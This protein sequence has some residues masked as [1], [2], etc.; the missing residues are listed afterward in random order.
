MISRF[1]SATGII[2]VPFV[3]ARPMSG[4]GF[5]PSTILTH[6]SEQTPEESND[7]QL[8]DDVVVAAVVVVV[9]GDVGVAAVVVSSGVGFFVGVVVVEFATAFRI[10]WQRIGCV[11]C[12]L[13]P[14]S[15]GIVDTVRCVN[16]NSTGV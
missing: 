1:G 9:S 7:R 16:N 5:F 8:D 10:R 3:C 14:L 15:L 4:Y 12:T 2:T 13:S 11:S 6:I